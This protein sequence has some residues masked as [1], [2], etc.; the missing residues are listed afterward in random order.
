MSRTS[1]TIDLS[2]MKKAA[3]T[4][5]NYMDF[6]NTNGLRISQNKT[7]T[8]NTANYIQI[9]NSELNVYNSGNKVAT[10]GSSISLASNEATVTIGS[11]SKYHTIL[12][13]TGIQF[14][15]GANTTNSTL[16][17]ISG[18]Q[19]TLYKSNTNTAAA[20]LDSNGLAIAAGSITL[21]SNFAVTSAGALTATNA[22]ITGS[23]TANS[24]TARDYY[25]NAYRTRAVV[26]TNGLT[27]Y[28]GS[29]TADTNIQARFGTTIQLGKYNNGYLSI[30]NNCF[31]FYH[32][33]N[34]KIGTLYLNTVQGLESYSEL[35]LERKE[36]SDQLSNLSL[37]KNGF[38]LYNSYTSEGDQVNINCSGLSKINTPRLTLGIQCNT[39]YGNEE[40]QIKFTLLTGVGS[41][42]SLNADSVQINGTKWS[43]ITYGTTDPDSSTQGD[44]YIKY[45][46]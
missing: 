17:S 39:R 30:S 25:N 5:T 13:N 4:A 28:D 44:I 18:N 38:K 2:S 27:I 36:A 11:T 14:K 46:N 10:F 8:G 26:D 40:A 1:T 9:N 42:I 22:T 3:Q 29:G 37:Y 43:A 33:T 35:I 6:D 23:I 41:R 34:N 45:T 16:M 20:T 7:Y 15:N 21:G 12:S 24:F 19:I 32:Q 31:N